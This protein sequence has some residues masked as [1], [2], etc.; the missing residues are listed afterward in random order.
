MITEKDFTEIYNA[1]A[2]KI[3]RLCLGYAQG[4]EDLS[5]EW[6]QETFIKV[7]NHRKSFNKES[8]VSTWIY[9][10][11]VNVCLGDLRKPK[12][13]ISL[14]ENNIP[15]QIEEEHQDNQNKDINK[16]YGCINQLTE[17]NKALILLEL[18]DIPQATIAET[19]GLAHNAIRTR[20]SRIRKALLKCMTNGK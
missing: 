20:L 2:S 4:D 8:S 3:F 17:Q 10:I 16:L 12:K 19:V 9:R 11:A 13:T 15:D 18:E 6:L 14:K 1:H 7:W 5:K